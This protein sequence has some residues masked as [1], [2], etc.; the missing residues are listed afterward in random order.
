MGKPDARVGNSTVVLGQLF[1]PPAVSCGWVSQS[2]HMFSGILEWILTPNFR[3]EM[4][5]YFTSY[6]SA[7]IEDRGL[8]PKLFSR[9]STN[10][11][12]MDAVSKSKSHPDFQGQ[13]LVS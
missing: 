9:K 12:R 8:K 10:G 4:L 1:R 6:N 5:Q 3:A 2:I 13:D 7:G 11:H